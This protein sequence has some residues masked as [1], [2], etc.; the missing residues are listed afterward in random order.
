L[1]KNNPGNTSPGNCIEDVEQKSIRINDPFE[2]LQKLI[3]LVDRSSEAWFGGAGRNRTDD[4]LLAKQVLSQ[5]SYSPELK[6]KSLRL[7]ARGMCPAD[8]D[9]DGGPG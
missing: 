3:T 4:P 7:I 2:H 1:S 5:L 9:S 6:G 8:Q